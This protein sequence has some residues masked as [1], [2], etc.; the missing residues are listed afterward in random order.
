MRGKIG[1]CS[2]CKGKH[3]CTVY[4]LLCDLSAIRVHCPKCHRETKEEHVRYCPFCGF[5]VLKVPMSNEQVAPRPKKT[6]Q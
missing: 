6:K 2:E 4:A 5:H 3:R 1:S